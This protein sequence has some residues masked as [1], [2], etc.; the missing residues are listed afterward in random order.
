[1]TINNRVF[2]NLEIVFWDTTIPALSVARSLR[3]TMYKF[4]RIIRSYLPPIWLRGIFLVVCSAFGLTF[5][6]LI[7]IVL[8]TL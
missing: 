2:E 4:R 7:G 1:M 6:L 5:G 8:S 3:Q